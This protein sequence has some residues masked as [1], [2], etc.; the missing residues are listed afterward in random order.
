MKTN[1]TPTIKPK[2]VVKAKLYAKEI[3][4]S[5]SQIFENQLNELIESVKIKRVD[6]SKKYSGRLKV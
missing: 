4:L 6:V 5:L 3:N 1:P 2:L